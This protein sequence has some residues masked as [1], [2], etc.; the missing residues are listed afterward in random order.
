MAQRIL[1][2]GRHRDQTFVALEMT[3]VIVVGLEMID[4]DHDQSQTLLF[5]LGIPERID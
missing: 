1:Q 4:I 5:F 3:E 2:G